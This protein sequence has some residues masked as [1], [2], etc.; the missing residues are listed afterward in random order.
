MNQ[1][2]SKIVWVDEEFAY[3][4]GLELKEAGDM[5]HD[6]QENG[7]SDREVLVNPVPDLDSPIVTLDTGEIVGPIKQLQRIIAIDVLR[8][9][10]LLGILIMNIRALA[11]IWQNNDNPHAMGEVSGLNLWVWLVGDLFTDRKMMAIFSMLF[12]AGI[13]IMATRMEQT[14]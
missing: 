8:G 10:A 1:P 9:V 13:V 5:T 11:S 12:G 4:S 14:N 2:A 3:T 7:H 6:S